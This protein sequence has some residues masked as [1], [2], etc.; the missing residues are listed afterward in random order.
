VIPEPRIL[1]LE[2]A[3][4]AGSIAV[5]KGSR[6]LAKRVGRPDVSHSNTLLSDIDEILSGTDLS[7]RDID[8]FAV[9]SGPGSFTGLRIGLATVKALATTL[10]RPCIGVPTLEAIAHS[11]GVADAVVAL[12]PAGRGEVFVQMF[13]T[14]QGAVSALDQPRHLSPDKAI[15]QYVGR[16]GIRWAGEGARLYSDLIELRA[17]SAGYRFI[18]ADKQETDTVTDAWVITIPTSTL[19]EHVT[20]LAL[21][22]VQDGLP[23][24][25]NSLKAI[26]VR[27]SDAEMKL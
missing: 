27:P 5:S 24:T 7:I 2:T 16:A 15:D 12:L 26:Y 14:L 6:I 18:V 23:A 21:M 8:L 1:S 22:R 10:D 20:S 17:T 19:A 3:T 4:L 9:A 13:S 25:A 11:A